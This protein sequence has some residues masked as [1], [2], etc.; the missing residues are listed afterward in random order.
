MDIRWI[1][2]AIWLTGKVGCLRNMLLMLPIIP[3]KLNHF[4]ENMPSSTTCN[5]NKKSQSHCTDKT[6]Q[7]SVCL[8]H[9]NYCGRPIATPW[10]QIVNCTFLHK[11]TLA[12]SNVKF[13]SFS[14]EG[15]KY[16]TQF[17]NVRNKKSNGIPLW[18]GT[19][20]VSDNMDG[21]ESLESNIRISWWT[22]IW[23]LLLLCILKAKIKL[24][25]T[26]NSLWPLNS[27]VKLTYVF[28]SECGNTT[29]L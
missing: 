29:G 14:F 25:T 20:I 8:Y 2:A 6:P 26:T 12:G 18:E 7:C 28:T 9:C 10:V 22:K 3:V 21:R 11:K 13:V 24:I 4:S 19:Y 17:T 16:C 5:C 27:P 23:N 1:Y 15:M